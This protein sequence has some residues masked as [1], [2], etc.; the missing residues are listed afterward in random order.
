VPEPDEAYHR[1]TAAITERVL[2]AALG[3]S[4]RLG[5]G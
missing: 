1:E 4:V 5:P 2:A 3:G